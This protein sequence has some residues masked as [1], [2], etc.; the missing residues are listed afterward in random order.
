[1]NDSFKYSSTIFCNPGLLYIE[2]EIK[3]L[4]LNRKLKSIIII[5]LLLALIFIGSIIL[6]CLTV[7][8]I[9]FLNKNFRYFIRLN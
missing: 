7:I 6:N 3:K 4:S 2:Q 1:M 8:S 9:R 5:N